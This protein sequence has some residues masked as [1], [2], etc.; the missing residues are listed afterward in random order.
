MAAANRRSS[1]ARSPGATARQAGVAATARAT[2]SSVCSAEVPGTE[3][4][5]SSV[6]GFRTVNADMRNSLSVTPCCQ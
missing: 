4:T 5:G 3:V 1:L 6:A 2:A